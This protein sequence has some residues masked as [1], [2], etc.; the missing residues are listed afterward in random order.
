MISAQ[1]K[2][3]LPDNENENVKHQTNKSSKNELSRGYLQPK[4]KMLIISL[5]INTADFFIHPIQAS[6]KSLC[7]FSI[8]HRNSSQYQENV[9]FKIAKSE[10]TSIPPQPVNHH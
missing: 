7:V 1:N 6:T 10:S 8:F 3:G 9:D 2:S 4:E 5:Y